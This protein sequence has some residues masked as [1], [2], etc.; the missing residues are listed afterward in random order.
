M[1][2]DSVSRRRFVRGVLGAAASLRVAGLAAGAEG[3]SAPPRRTFFD[4]RFPRAAGLASRLASDGV[5]EPIGGDPTELVLWVASQALQDP[6]I[7]GVTTGS[8]PFALQQL[9]LPGRLTVERIDRDLF[10]W[11]LV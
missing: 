9:R 2:N 11:A 4:A 5:L 1:L 6:R 7:A 10:V 3:R 8:V